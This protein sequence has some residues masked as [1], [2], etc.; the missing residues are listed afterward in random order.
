LASLLLREQKGR[1]EEKKPEAERERGEREVQR[2]EGL[3]STILRTPT[4]INLLKDTP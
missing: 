3:Y 1:G 2:Y 4:V